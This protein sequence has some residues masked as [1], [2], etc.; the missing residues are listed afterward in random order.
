[1]YSDVIYNSYTN[2]T[3]DYKI[4][5]FSTLTMSCNSHKAMF[6][7]KL[8]NLQC[9][10]VTSEFP[11]PLVRHLKLC[12]LD[13]HHILFHNQSSEFVGMHYLTT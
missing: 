10:H 6:Y 2:R 1:M 7:S 4:Q 8:I 9:K 11:H 5:L 13:A 3:Q 12:T